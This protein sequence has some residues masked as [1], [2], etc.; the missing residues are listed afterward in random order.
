MIN[1]DNLL[2]FPNISIPKTPWLYKSLLYWDTVDTITPEAF[3]KSHA[4]LMDNI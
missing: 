1:L 3:L 4:H 2:Y